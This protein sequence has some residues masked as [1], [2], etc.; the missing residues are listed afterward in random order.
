MVPTEI[1]WTRM[2]RGSAIVTNYNAGNQ[3]PM[4]TMISKGQMNKEGDY[5]SMLAQEPEDA[6]YDL[7]NHS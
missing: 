7:S 4:S 5:S 1:S 6:Y 2:L 3:V